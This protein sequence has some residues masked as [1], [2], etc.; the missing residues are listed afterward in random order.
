MNRLFMVVAMFLIFGCGAPSKDKTALKIG[1]IKI[2]AQEFDAA[3]KASGMT[4]MGEDSRKQFLERFIS[5]KLILSEAEKIGLDK[6]SQ[7]L[8]SVQ[9]FWEQSLLKLIL[10]QKSKEFS[11]NARVDDSEIAA[12]YEKRKEVSFPGKELTEV[13]A[14]IKWILLKQKQSQ[15]LQ[16]WI[17]SLEGAVKIES[18]YKLLGIN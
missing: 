18:D 2:T 7:F 13:H 4:Y 15:A 16:E 6:D 17:S 12:Y 8:E 10:A 14:Q 9:I 1:D 11:S 3:F 5:R